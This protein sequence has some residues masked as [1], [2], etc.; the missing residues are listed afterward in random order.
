MFNLSGQQF[1]FMNDFAQA[2]NAGIHDENHVWENLV[3]LRVTNIPEEADLQSNEM[4]IDHIEALYP[5]YG[6]GGEALGWAINCSQ[7]NCVTLLLKP[8]GF[9]Q[10][11]MTEEELRAYYGRRGFEYQNGLM[12]RDPSLHVLPSSSLHRVPQEA[13][14]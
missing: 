6:H 3:D 5:G 4:F 7:N 9:G 13:F 8:Q 2:T 1:N 12:V 11:I 10:K 14:C